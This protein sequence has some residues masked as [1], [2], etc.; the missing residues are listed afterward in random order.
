MSDEIASKVSTMPSSRFL[1]VRVLVLLVPI[2]RC[3]VGGSGVWEKKKRE[4]TGGMARSF[5]VPLLLMVVVTAGYGARGEGGAVLVQAGNVG[6]NS[7]TS[8]C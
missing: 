1:R 4:S 2:M 7:V 8:K 3:K 5:S 6:D